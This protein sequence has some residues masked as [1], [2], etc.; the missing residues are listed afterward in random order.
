[1][2]ISVILEKNVLMRQRIENILLIGMIMF[3]WDHFK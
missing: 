1:M 3:S 2:E